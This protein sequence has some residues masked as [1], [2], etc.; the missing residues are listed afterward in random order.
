MGIFRDRIH[1]IDWTPKEDG[2]GVETTV[3]HDRVE[4]EGFQ[5]NIAILPATEQVVAIL[6]ALTGEVL[7]SGTYGPGNPMVW[8]KPGWRGYVKIQMKEPPEFAERSGVYT[9]R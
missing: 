9:P 4:A 2:T 1:S 5:E 8:R 6:N 3:W 7:A